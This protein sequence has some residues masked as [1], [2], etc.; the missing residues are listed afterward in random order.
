[1]REEMRPV[2]ESSSPAGLDRNRACRT[3]PVAERSP[4]RQEERQ[5]VVSAAVVED[6]ALARETA[7]GAVCM[8]KAQAQARTTQA[9]GA[10]P[11]QTHKGEFRNILGRE[12]RA[13]A[14]PARPPCPAYR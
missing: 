10:A 6:R 8:A 3:Q 13:T 14:P 11:I 9:Q 4:C 7:P 5:R 12:E 2:P 1:M